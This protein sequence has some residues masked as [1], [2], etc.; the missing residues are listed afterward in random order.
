MLTLPNLDRRIETMNLDIRSEAQSLQQ[1]REKASPE[2]PAKIDLSMPDTRKMTE[3]LR[4]AALTNMKK[5]DA[6]DAI[7]NSAFWRLI[8]KMLGQDDLLTAN[9]STGY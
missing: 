4:R 5:R 3:R 2:S 6:R 7:R 9:D 8:R 1:I